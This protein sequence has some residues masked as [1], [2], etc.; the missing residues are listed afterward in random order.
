MIRERP[1]PDRA[2]HSPTPA[3]AAPAE[4]GPRPVIEVYR[5]PRVEV[6]RRRPS[7]EFHRD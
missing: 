6:Y 3:A 5:A 2:A 1:M 7:G 4:P